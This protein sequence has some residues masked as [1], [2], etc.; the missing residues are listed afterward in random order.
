MPFTSIP[1]QQEPKLAVG[2]VE[3][4]TKVAA[5]P[6]EQPVLPWERR[7]GVD[8]RA[9]KKTTPIGQLSK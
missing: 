8:K 4:G 9:F 2:S 5:E 7:S 3:S 6:A 1:P